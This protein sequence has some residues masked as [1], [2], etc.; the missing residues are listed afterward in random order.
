MPN[1]VT[2][3]HT[4]LPG[5][6]KPQGTAGDKPAGCRAR[7]APGSTGTADAR[8]HHSAFIMPQPGDG[9]GGPSSSGYAHYSALIMPQPSD[10]DPGPSS[11]GYA[12]HSALIM[13]Q[14]SD[15]SGGPS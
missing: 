4:G 9:G 15:G 1:G 3:S 5:G 6:S 8:A 2:G 14:P 7:Q 11:S 12:H 13:P 10:P